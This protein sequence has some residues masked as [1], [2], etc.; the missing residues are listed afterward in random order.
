MN[1]H[2]ELSA[3][4]RENLKKWA[5]KNWKIGEKVNPIWHSVIVDECAIMLD[6]EIR[7][8]THKYDA[9]TLDW[10]FAY[11]DMTIALDSSTDEISE[12]EQLEMAIEHF[13][14]VEWEELINGEN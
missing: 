3:D 4:E 11:K 1:L 6:E 9:G 14:E 2:K 12:E 7:K 13:W 8:N 10:N 5:R